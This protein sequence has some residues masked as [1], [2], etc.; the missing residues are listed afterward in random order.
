MRG[1]SSLFKLTTIIGKQVTLGGF[2][3]PLPLSGGVA[4]LPC[5]SGLV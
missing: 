5:G 4:E 3:L 2:H 1:Q